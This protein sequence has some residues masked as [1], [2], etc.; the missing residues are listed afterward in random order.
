MW[1]WDDD[2]DDQGG[3]CVCE[4]TV[5]TRE[6]EMSDICNKVLIENSQDLSSIFGNFFGTRMRK[7]QN[8]FYVIGC[9]EKFGKQKP[10][11]I[12]EVA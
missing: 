3:V 11:C 1:W 7:W 8:C 12:D 2:D 5:D 10:H 9:K 6:T 4:A